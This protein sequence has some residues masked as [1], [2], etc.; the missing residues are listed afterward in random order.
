M[1][2]ISRLTFT[3]NQSRNG[4]FKR[5]G[6]KT[7]NALNN[8]VKIKKLAFKA[9]F[10]KQLMA[11]FNT[12]NSIAPSF[13][14]DE[15]D[16]EKLDNYEIKSEPCIEIKSEEPIVFHS[17]RNFKNLEENNLNFSVKKEVP[18][19]YVNTKNSGSSGSK[20]IPYEGNFRSQKLKQF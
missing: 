6:I 3:A 10:D 18:F 16:F 4:A 20:S 2:H 14:K 7:R 19:F 11:S 12:M 9:R 1:I 15:D 8:L 5:L 13:T 17:L